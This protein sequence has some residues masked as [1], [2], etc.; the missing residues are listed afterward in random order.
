MKNNA[1][2]HRTK[3]SDYGGVDTLFSPVQII[4]CN[5]VTAEKEDDKLTV[6][7]NIGHTGLQ[8]TF[9]KVVGLISTPI[10]QL[11]NQRCVLRFSPGHN[12]SLRFLLHCILG[13]L[14]VKLLKL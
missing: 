9:P 3:T 14:E 5:C 8:I 10:T 7:C 4:P 12:Y 6:T 11:Q 1:V 2:L 13:I